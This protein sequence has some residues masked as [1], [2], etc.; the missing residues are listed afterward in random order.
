MASSDTNQKVEDGTFLA[1]EFDIPARKAARLV[2][3]EGDAGKVEAGVHEK[4]R[5]ADALEGVPT[6]RASDDLTTDTDETRL[7]PVLHDKNNR[8]GAG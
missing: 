6:P 7:K 8:T 3:S 4:L 5:S 1:E 2:S